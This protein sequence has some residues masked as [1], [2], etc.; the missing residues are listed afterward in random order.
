MIWLLSGPPGL[1]VGFLLLRYSVLCTFESLSLLY[2]IFICSRRW[3]MDKGSLMQTKNRC[4]LIHIWTK[5]EV[6]TS[7]NWFKPSSKIFLLAVPKRYFFC[8]SFELFMSCVLPWFCVCSL[9]HCGHLKGKGWTLCSCLWCLLWF[10]Y[11]L[12]WYPGTGVVLDFVD[13]WSLLSFSLFNL[14]FWQFL[15]TFTCYLNICIEDLP[16]RSKNVRFY[17]SYGNKITLK[18]LFWCEKSY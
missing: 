12:I 15:V 6:C 2:L 10:C 13:S 1:T 5:N 18:C 16:N 17:L 7:W 3:C 11:F 4:V 14:W 8:G 9:L